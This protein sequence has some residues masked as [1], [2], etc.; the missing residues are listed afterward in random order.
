MPNDSAQFAP[1]GPLIMFSSFTSAGIGDSLHCVCLDEQEESVIGYVQAMVNGVS[2]DD[3][4]KEGSS[5][6]LRLQLERSFILSAP[7]MKDSFSTICDMRTV[8][9]RVG[10]NYRNSRYS[11]HS[12]T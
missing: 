11:I 10:D 8:T 7:T 3:L 9:G 2:G 1:C 6:S 12:T 5:A 4:D